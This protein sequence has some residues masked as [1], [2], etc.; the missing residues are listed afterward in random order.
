[1]SVVLL[2]SRIDAIAVR[3][4]VVTMI[5]LMIAFLIFL[6]IFGLKTKPY[7]K[8]ARYAIQFLIS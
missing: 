5:I 1:M 7:F 6:F 8:L 2:R 3:K 4:T